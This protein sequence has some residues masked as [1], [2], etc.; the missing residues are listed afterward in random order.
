MS[1]PREPAVGLG[2]GP[3]PDSDRTAVAH[4][5]AT[6]AATP[7]PALEWQFNP[8]RERP[9]AAA[10]GLACVGGTVALSWNLGLAPLHHVVLALLMFTMLGALIV[11]VRCRIDDQGVARGG[12]IGWE[13]RRWEDIRRAVRV[14]GGLLVSPFSEPRRLD[15]FRALLLPMHRA[16]R[17]DL[18]ASVRPHLVL[19]GL[20]V[21]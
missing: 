4:A 9:T 5:D 7:P 19:H 10:I 11:P 17:R 16:E 8:W 6:A 3:G 15:A 1:D 18:D 2:V 14:R 12:A 13:R 21:S 20:A